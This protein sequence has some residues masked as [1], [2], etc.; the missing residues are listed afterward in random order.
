MSY[1]IFIT[2]PTALIPQPG[3]AVNTFPS[4]LVRVDQT[5]LGLTS[6]A[7][8]HRATLAIGND[9]PDSDSSPCMDGLKIFPAP[10][11]R[12]RE[13]GFT[14]YLV[15]AYGRKNDTGL[16][17]IK[18]EIFQASHTI[19]SGG[20]SSTIEGIFKQKVV[21]ILQVLTEIEENNYSFSTGSIQLP[22][23]QLINGDW[24]TE[25]ANVFEQGVA[26]FSSTNYGRFRE[27]TIIINHFK[28][29]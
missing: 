7:T 22:Y 14:E 27:A 16:T 17:S 5:Y 23:P 15:S 19:S 18:W 11:E 6:K 10:Q 20:E 26:S 24:S 28:K 12:R 29:I 25:W 8:T 2:S 13:D 4:G 1:S 3:R 21:T 9:M